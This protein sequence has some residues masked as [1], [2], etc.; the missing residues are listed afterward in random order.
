MTISSYSA[1]AMHQ[2][3]ASGMK[4]LNTYYAQQGSFPSTVPLHPTITPAPLLVG[5]L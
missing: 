3:K 5:Q 1:L 2:F 4:K